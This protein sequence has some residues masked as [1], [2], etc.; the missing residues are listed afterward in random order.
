MASEIALRH[1]LTV[2]FVALLGLVALA[3]TSTDAA[4]RRMGPNWKRMHRAAH[5]IGALALLHFFIQSKV[6]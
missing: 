3:A 5:L 4:V 2:G 6:N 1:Y